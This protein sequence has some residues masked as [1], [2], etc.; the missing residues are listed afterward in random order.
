RDEDLFLLIKYRELT[1]MAF[2]DPANDNWR[3]APPAP[4]EEDGR[5]L[6]EQINQREMIL[7]EDGIEPGIEEM[8]DLSGVPWDDELEPDIANPARVKLVKVDKAG[9]EW[10]HL[11]D[12]EFIN[13]AYLYRYGDLQTP[14]RRNLKKP[15]EMRA[16]RRPKKKCDPSLVPNTSGTFSIEDHIDAR[17]EVRRIFDKLPAS[18]IRVVELSL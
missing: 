2:N 7:N 9:T 16:P 8:R 4:G 3:E 13:G 17:E 6:E 11:G 1:D 10:R 15:I 18:V 12:L 14:D 5:A